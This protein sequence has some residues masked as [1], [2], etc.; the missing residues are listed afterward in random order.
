M[1]ALSFFVL[2]NDFSLIFQGKEIEKMIVVAVKRLQ[3]IQKSTQ[4]SSTVV[5]INQFY[6]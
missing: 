6:Y 4:I 5:G 3:A 1:N 2:S